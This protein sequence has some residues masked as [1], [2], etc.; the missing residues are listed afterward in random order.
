[1]QRAATPLLDRRYEIAAILTEQ[2]HERHYAARHV[3]LAMP[4]RIVVCERANSF[5]GVGT[6]AGVRQS[7]VSGSWPSVSLL[8]NMRHPVL[9]RVRDCFRHSTLYYVVTDEVG[10][11][12]LSTRLVRGDRLSPA[13]VLSIGL[14]LCDALA[15]LADF[16]PKLLPLATITP[17]TVALL[18]SGVVALTCLPV[19]RWLGTRS[20]PAVPHDLLYTAPELLAGD[21]DGARVDVYSVATLLYILLASE[22]DMCAG[23]PQLQ[24]ADAAPH[25][26][27]GL[28]AAVERGV[29]PDASQRFASAFEFGTALAACAYTLL[30]AS[31]PSP[32]PADEPTP[33]RV[34]R[35]V[36]RA[37]RQQQRPG[38]AIPLDK[39]RPRLRAL[40]TRRPD[41][42]RQP[43]LLR[44]G[45]RALAALSSALHRSA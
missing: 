17:E 14:Q 7:P 34:S 39:G 33:A 15:Y 28:V 21:S 8:T 37:Q 30:P 18:P 19:G 6:N 24:L 44:T 11:E 25:L 43:Y 45:E 26:P 32:S 4:V 41:S 20:D 29:H 38:G 35:S 16:A 3:E 10:G 42:S 9:P 2:P 40:P 36:S 22:P 12:T 5:P 23:C 1:M 31:V 27:V 13:Q